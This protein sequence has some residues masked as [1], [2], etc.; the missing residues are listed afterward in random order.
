[1]TSSY[2]TAAKVYQSKNKYVQQE[3]AIEL[4]ELSQMKEGD[5]VLDIG[6]GCGNLAAIMSDIVG[7]TG[8]VIAIDPDLNRIKAAKKA[9]GSK[10][11]ITFIPCKSTVFPLDESNLYDV[12]I[13]NAVLHWIPT[14]EKMITFARVN[15]ALK[16]DGVFVGNISFSRSYNL[17]LAA[18]LLSPEEEFQINNFYYRENYKKLYS[19]FNDA[20]FQIIEYKK[21]FA[22]I[23][24]GTVDNF[25]EWVT[26][27]YYGK[28]DFKKAYE[29]SEVTEEDFEKLK[30]GDIRHISEGATFV[31]R[32]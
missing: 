4:L 27:T 7:P 9:F 6:C 23:N 20:G 1:M 11:N 8:Q 18:T 5:H 17:Q 13:T 31:L 25:L 14:E 19:L 30:N 15:Q 24:M 32:R 10:K 22:E 3:Y 21:R 26:A 12:I 16:P 2:T 28:F 29:N